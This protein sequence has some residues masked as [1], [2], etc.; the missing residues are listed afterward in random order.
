MNARYGYTLVQHSGFAD[1]GNPAFERGLEPAALML[2]KTFDQVRRAG[3]LTFGVYADAADAALNHSYPTGTEGL[4]PQAPGSFS[5]KEVDGRRV[6][7]PPSGLAE[8]A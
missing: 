1:G 7:I 2:K 4:I 8:G 3:G 5:D 6:Y